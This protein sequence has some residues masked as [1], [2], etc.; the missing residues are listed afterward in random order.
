LKLL[1][2]THALLWWLID[3]P[4]LSRKAHASLK[5]GENVVYVSAISAYEVALKHGMGKLPEAEP[6]AQNFVEQIEAAG[7]EALPL[8][9]REA[10]VAGRMTNDHRDPFDRML[11]AQAILRDLTLVSNERVF[12]GFGVARLW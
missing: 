12:D 1:L 3:D 5:S 8:S 9:L 7:F 2:D 4:R 11:I 10:Q 6:L